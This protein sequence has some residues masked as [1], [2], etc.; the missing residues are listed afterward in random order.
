[1]QHCG[2]GHATAACEAASAKCI[3]RAFTKKQEVRKG[4]AACVFSVTAATTLGTA[5]H[6]G[7]CHVPGV[8]FPSRVWLF[9]SYPGFRYKLRVALLFM[10]I[11]GIAGIGGTLVLKAAHPPATDTA[12]TLARV[13][14]PL[15]G[16]DAVPAATA[17]HAEAATTGQRPRQPEGSKAACEDNTWA[18][19][20]GKC[21]SGRPRKARTARPATGGPLI[22]AIPL[23]S[24][25]APARER[26]AEPAPAPMSGPDRRQQG[27]VP[28]EPPASAAAAAPA[29]PAIAKPTEQAAAAPKKAQKTA[30]RQSKSRD[31]RVASSAGRAGHARDHQPSARAYADERSAQHAPFG[32]GGLFGGGGP[33]GSLFR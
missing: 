12:L 20:D 33:F 32:G 5:R 22:S 10:A 19:L 13:D 3:H 9:L 28:S 4:L 30:R 27:S 6:A 25:S 2:S 8:S 14:H 24:S 15:S 21:V 1:M 29:D 31:H 7:G 11:G 18:Y 17:D 23:G 26:A 16:G